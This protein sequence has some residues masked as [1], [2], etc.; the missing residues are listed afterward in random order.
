[1]IQS[2]LGGSLFPNDEK[3]KKHKT[4]F[5]IDRNM[6]FSHVNRLIRC[7]IDSQLQ[8][9]DAVSI[10]HALELARSLAARVW[11]N[12]PYQMK[13]LDA[14]GEAFVRKL[15]QAGISS[16][17]TLQH[18]EPHRIE[19]IVGRNPPFGQ[20]VIAKA[21]EFPNLRVSVKEI[22]KEIRHGQ[23][24]GIKFKA[25]VGF[26]NE[27]PPVIF[28]RKSVYVCFLAETSDGK[29]IDF[30]RFAAKKLEHGQ[31]ILLSVQLIRPTTSIICHTMC[32]EI[33]GTGRRVELHLEHFP[34]SYFSTNNS[35]A[36][37]PNVRESSK[38][39]ATARLATNSA[40]AVEDYGDLDDADLLAA[41]DSHGDVEVIHDIDQFVLDNDQPAKQSLKR[42]ASQI[43]TDEHGSS[44][45]FKEPVQLANGNWTCQHTCKEEGKSCKHKCCADGVEKP[46]RLSRKKA[47]KEVAPV[48][49]LY[50][51]KTASKPAKFTPFEKARSQTDGKKQKLAVPKHPKA[52]IT[53]DRHQA[54]ATQAAHTSSAPSKAPA[55]QYMRGTAPKLSFMQN[56]YELSKNR[57]YDVEE[58]ADGEAERSKDSEPS[59]RPEGDA[60]QLSDFDFDFEIDDIAI[61][62]MTSLAKRRE[63]SGKSCFGTGHAPTNAYPKKDGYHGVDSGPEDGVPGNVRSRHGRNDKTRP[64]ASEVA[65]AEVHP[66]TVRASQDEVHSLSSLGL[67]NEA[68]FGAFNAPLTHVSPIAI[69][70]WAPINSN[71]T[72]LQARSPK[73]QEKGLF[74]TSGSSSPYKTLPRASEGTGE[75]DEYADVAVEAFF[76]T[77]GATEYDVVEM[78]AKMQKMNR[79]PNDLM[80]SAGAI[81]ELWPSIPEDSSTPEFSEMSRPPLGILQNG[82]HYQHIASKEDVPAGSDDL[83]IAKEKKEEKA[84]DEKMKKWEG[85]EDFYEQFGDYVEIVE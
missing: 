80:M 43:S 81:P 39:N 24:V 72:I 35:I 33:A 51:G 53:A 50:T 48:R 3:W 37:K 69:Q 77:L 63:V 47:N 76:A 40:S 36:V 54:T 60:T 67:G 75:T 73:I 61:E 18:T 20:K 38:G 34:D 64:I 85:L 55:Y 49:G 31:D 2:E 26:I 52:G 59:Q 78:P 68:D 7:V 82:Q 74:I 83:S 70:R 84:E 44:K 66:P 65:N 28:K 10:R 15:A 62:K 29:L 1:L 41:L 16:I 46:A 12:S 17:E 8:L 30:R 22:G 79:D 27:K 23:G 56:P 45:P 5:N 42:A 32:D 4:Q 13:Q 25:E 58:G 6:V 14:I 71:R 11:D 57:T 19:R 9:E 21:L